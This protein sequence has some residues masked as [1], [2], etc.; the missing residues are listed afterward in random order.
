MTDKTIKKW[1]Y[2]TNERDKAKMKTKNIETC[3]AK[4]C[5]TWSSKANYYPNQAG[6][7]TKKNTHKLKMSYRLHMQWN[8]SELEMQNHTM[9][10]SEA[11]ASKKIKIMT[12]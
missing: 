2:A 9:K 11:H 4:H 8:L 1:I 10:I 6:D 12:K 7:M 5:H 3:Y